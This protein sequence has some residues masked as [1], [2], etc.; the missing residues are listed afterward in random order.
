MAVYDRWHRDPR[1]GDQPCKCGK[2]RQK[3]YPSAVHLKGKRWQV[4]WDDPDSA[5][6]RQPRKNRSA[7]SRSLAPASISPAAASRTCSRRARSAAVSPPPSGYLM[8][9]AY[10]ARQPSAE[11]VTPPLKIV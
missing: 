5:S 3:L 8:T 4:R 11:P 6:R 7:A 9:P 1:P 2:G 10:P